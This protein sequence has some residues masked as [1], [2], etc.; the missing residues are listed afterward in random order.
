M[1]LTPRL[2]GTRPALSWWRGQRQSRSVVPGRGGDER[3]SSLVG[4][5]TGSVEHGPQR[6]DGRVMKK[7]I[8]AVLSFAFLMSFS[9][10]VG[11]AQTAACPDVEAAKTMLKQMTARTED[12]QAPRSLA[13]AR[14]QDVQAPRSQ[15]VQAPRSQD[16]QAPR[17]QDIQ[18]PRS[19]D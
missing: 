19:Q 18:A 16:V 13:G 7:A 4:G 9:P 8:S 11:S 6:K 17:S 14:S 1:F 2:T 12:V 15:D 5:S 3:W 10:T